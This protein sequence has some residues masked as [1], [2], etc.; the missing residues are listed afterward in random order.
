MPLTR[1]RFVQVAAALPVAALGAEHDW[2]SFRGAGACGVAD[3][4]PVRASW[5]ADAA[6]GSVS[7]VRWHVPE[8][9]ERAILPGLRSLASARKARIS[10]PI[11][12]FLRCRPISSRAR[13]SG[14]IEAEFSHPITT[15][16]TPCRLKRPA[17]RS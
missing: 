5:N 11:R 7:G 2:P 15:S 9:M 17:S 1:R 6:A 12:R 8:S 16:T 10:S 3:G 14:G 4:Y 13:G